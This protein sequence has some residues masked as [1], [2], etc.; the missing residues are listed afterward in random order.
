M[1]KMSDVLGK[2]NAKKITE[3]TRGGVQYQEEF[4]E[5]LYSQYRWQNLPKGLTSRYFETNL[6]DNFSMCFAVGKSGGMVDKMV[7]FVPTEVQLNIYDEPTHV[8]GTLRDGTEISADDF[9][10]CRDRTGR[11]T[12]PMIVDWY[13]NQLEEIDKTI[14][15]NLKLQRRPYIVTCNEGAKISFDILMSKLDEGVEVIKVKEDM[16]IKANVD[17]LSFNA[18]FVIDKLEE[19][20]RMIRSDCLTALGINNVNV[21]KRER[22][23]SGEVNANNEDIFLSKNSRTRE[24]LEFCERYKEV[25]GT[26]YGEIPTFVDSFAEMTKEGGE[27]G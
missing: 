5:K 6:V 19:H 22:L 11:L 27:N 9:A 18:P 16:N 24:R 25:F 3:K 20:K 10:L 26:R 12:S 4:L 13:A 17:V 8:Y 1:G 7:C 14:A 15:S 21:I 23:V 2:E